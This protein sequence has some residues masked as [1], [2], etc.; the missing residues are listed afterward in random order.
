MYGY[1][2]DRGNLE[3]MNAGECIFVLFIFAYSLSCVHA[4]LFPPL[5]LYTT[6][7]NFEGCPSLQLNQDVKAESGKQK[8]KRSSLSVPVMS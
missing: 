3:C 4:F 8:D 7:E 6:R 1:R 2:S 5:R